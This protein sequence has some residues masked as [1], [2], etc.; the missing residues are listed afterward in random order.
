MIARV[1]V[2]AGHSIE[3]DT[4]DYLV[5]DGVRLEAG[6]RVSVP[7]GRTKRQGYVLSLSEQ[8]EV[9]LSRLRPIER[10][11]DPFPALSPDTL[12]VARYLSRTYRMPLAQAI[13]AIL[14]SKLRDGSS[15]RKTERCIELAVE[16]E[17]L[18]KARASLLKKDGTVRYE[19]QYEVLRCLEESPEGLPSAN[20]PASAVRTLIKKGF[21][22][23]H[24]DRSMLL[25]APGPAP[26]AAETLELVPQQKAAVDRILTSGGRKFLL[27]GVTGSGKTEVYIQVVRHVLSQGKSAVLLVP[28]I[29]LTPQIYEYIR[30]RLGVEVA[31]FHSKLTEAERFEQWMLARSGAARVV[32]GP[33]SAIFAPVENIGAIIIDEEQ[34]DSYKSGRYPGYTARE[35]AQYRADAN[36][37]F[38]V[39]G[40]ATPSIETYQDALSG[41]LECVA[42]PNRLFNAPLPRVEIVDMREEV[43]NGNPGIVSSKLDDA[44]RGALAADEQ[45]M[46]L[47]NRRG[48][49]SFLMCTS[50]GNAVGCEQCDVS[51]TYHKS[52]GMLKCHYCGERQPVP[53]QCPVCGGRLRRVGIG[54]QKLEEELHRLYPSARILRMD[55][56]T[57]SGRMAHKDAYDSFREGTADILIGTQM[58]AK[59]FDFDR[60]SVAAV[61][62]A[63]SILHVPSYR[64]PER[65]FDHITQLAGRAGR[66]GGGEV[67]IQTYNPEHYAIQHAA[68]HD[69]KG[70]FA[71]ESA[72]RRKM[73]LPPY[74][75]HIVIRFN[76]QDEAR[77]Q[78][79]AKD[80]LGRMRSSLAPFEGSIVRARASEAP[81]RRIEGAYRYQILVH[82]REKD[83]RVE[84]AIYDLLQ[85]AQYNGVLVGVDINP[86]DL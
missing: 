20:L 72:Y 34:E 73:L 67:Y 25:S 24:E 69:F 85:N 66:R 60:V 77:A 84:E 4:F 71:V 61:V 7:F 2:D 39:L 43:K 9:P 22:R 75:Q 81:I 37:A 86:S 76:S 10:A 40:S 83:H 65:A 36:D 79:A 51:M 18:E 35:I 6:T 45:V 33:R 44:I 42:M 59:G 53:D 27:H 15:A 11:V 54:T 21:V 48:Y 41:G 23:V 1:A 8:S 63:D 57:M 14:P 68:R 49:S 58:I 30:G 80:F 17:E 70:F 50:C 32:L 47:L 12:D 26:L 19:Q 82:L 78:R 29:S 62:A 52:E 13:R 3:K 74:G 55:A 28:E 31:L 64:S 46:I 16:G 38:L 56:D 5:P